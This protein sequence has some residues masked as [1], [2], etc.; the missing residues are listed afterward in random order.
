MKSCYHYY[1]TNTVTPVY[2]WLIYDILL[3]QLWYLSSNFSVFDCCDLYI[4]LFIWS[5][6]HSLC[7]LAF[8]PSP[9]QSQPFLLF[10]LSCDTS[11]HQSPN[12]KVDPSA[13]HSKEFLD[14]T[15]LPLLSWSRFKKNFYIAIW[16]PFLTLGNIHTLLILE[17]NKSATPR[18]KHV[19]CC[20]QK[21]K[22]KGIQNSTK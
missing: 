16:T 14:F 4:W 8:V 3:I 7:L 15:P 10:F 5:G 11:V 2:D 17:I 9:K 12:K 18:I 21:K 20:S 1:R 13:N 6:D 22:N 19:H